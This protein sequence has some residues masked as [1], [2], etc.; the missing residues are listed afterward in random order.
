MWG[1]LRGRLVGE[2]EGPPPRVGEAEGPPRVGEGE[3]ARLRSRP[4]PGEGEGLRRAGEPVGSRR[5]GPATRL[6]SG[7]GEGAGLLPRVGE[8]EGWR[9]RPRAVLMLDDADADAEEEEEE[10][11]AVAAAGSEATAADF[12]IEDCLGTAGLSDGATALDSWRA[13]CGTDEVM[14]RSFVSRRVDR[15]TAVLGG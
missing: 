8:C 4:R 11:A 2:A 9:S 12:L 10:E 6:R 1:L 7:E 15:G 5:L 3:G 14:G 13:V